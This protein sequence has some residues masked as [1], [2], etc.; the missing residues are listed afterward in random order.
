MTQAK[1]SWVARVF[2]EPRRAWL[3][4]PWLGPIAALITVAL[5][6]PSLWLG[7]L[8]DDHFHRLTLLGLGTELLGR[9]SHAL[10]LFRFMPGDAAFNEAGRIQ[11]TLPWW[12]PDD[13][14]LA[15]WRPLASATHL[16]DYR[17]W[18]ETPALMHLHNLVWMAAFVVLAGRLYRRLGDPPAWI[19]GIA[20]LLF[21]LFSGHGV[22]ASWIA[23]RGALMA[24]VF[25][26]ACLIAHDRSVRE[27][28]T[29]AWIAAPVL[30]A[31]ALLS[32][33]IALGV[34]AYL[35]AYALVLDP[36]G[37]RRGLL[38]LLPAATVVVTWRTAYSML[39]YGAAG[40]LNYV[41]PIATPGRFAL[42][43]VER[44][45]LL[46]FKLLGG[47]PSHL[48]GLA[49]RVEQIGASIVAAVL[50]L[51]AAALLRAGFRASDTTRTQ[52]HFWSLGALGC[53]IPACATTSHDRLLVLAAIGSSMVIAQLLATI[54]TNHVGPGLRRLG[55]AWLISFG[56]FGPLLLVLDGFSLRIIQA[57]QVAASESLPAELEGRTLMVVNVPDPL[58]MCAQLP[59]YRA[60]R[61]EPYPETLR[62][63][64]ASEG[65]IEVRRPNPR[66][67]VLA[68]EDGY[69]IGP[70][71]A[72]L[73]DG[74][75]ERFVD[76][77][78]DLGDVR[79]EVLSTTADGRPQNVA[80]H[81]DEAPHAD[82]ERVW[83]VWT[84]DGFADFELPEVGERVVLEAQP[85]IPD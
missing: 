28:R 3:A 32:G 75:W 9:P 33:E 25:S 19:A 22:P 30:L 6:V 24:G 40:S 41:D 57:P 35:G 73:D 27:D 69:L 66:A 15:F 84:E 13:L 42:A 38:A 65:A 83:V 77:S 51:L 71:A 2:A 1:N 64:G 7:L 47:P 78:W 68:P 26:I 59:F 81:F 34:V 67:L 49:P 53:C 10:D 8:L 85:L 55:A 72:L 48:T 56:V 11:G 29:G 63:M 16:L 70:N 17:L 44:V 31:A 74:E 39:G 5:C 54:A 14:R 61:G 21:A 80:F 45:P 37:W 43:L 52:L 58:S 62:C 82:D 50:I 20:T 76:R 12:I 23:N 4:S 60:A 79:V 36:R 46:I 18:P